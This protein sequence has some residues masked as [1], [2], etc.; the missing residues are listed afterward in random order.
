MSN[1]Y[2]HAYFL[3]KA[4]RDSDEFQGLKKAFDTV[5]NNEI[6]KKMFEQFRDTQVAIQ[7]KQLQGLEI[8]EQDIEKAQQMYEVVTEQKDIVALFDAE[9]RLNVIIGDITRIITKP[10]DDLYNG[11]EAQMDE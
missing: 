9:Q 7:E 11:Y 2:D 10:L 8:T 4:F 5:M 1:L 6:T 3:E